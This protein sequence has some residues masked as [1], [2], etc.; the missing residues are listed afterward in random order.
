VLM[1]LCN[2]TDGAI[3]WFDADRVVRL[4]DPHHGGGTNVHLTDGHEFHLDSHPTQVAAEMN[5]F[6]KNECQE[7]PPTDEE[8]SSWCDPAHD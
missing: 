2:K 8:R 7:K 4:E 6:I 1:W 5:E 3:N